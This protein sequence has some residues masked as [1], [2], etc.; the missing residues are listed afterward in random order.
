MRYKFIEMKTG[1]IIDKEISSPTW[2]GL[3]HD[4]PSGITDEQHI[5]LKSHGLSPTIFNLN[6]LEELNGIVLTEIQAEKIINRGK[7]F[8]INEDPEIIKIN[9]GLEKIKDIRQNLDKD[10]KL[11]YEYKGSMIQ[12]K[13]KEFE[14]GN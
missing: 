10:E 1:K 9:L 6:C 7:V 3:H 4:K 2:I 13:L 14:N 11:L 8:N 12:E 5:F